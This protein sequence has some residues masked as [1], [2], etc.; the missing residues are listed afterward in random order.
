MKNLAAFTET[1]T[2]AGYPDFVSFNIDSDGNYTV[3]ARGS[4][5]QAFVV[6]SPEQ[7]AVL[8]GDVSANLPADVFDLVI[9]QMHLRAP[10][11]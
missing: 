4:T 3:S 10:V 6:M 9:T 8:I 5:G 11:E 1:P 7:F 2:P